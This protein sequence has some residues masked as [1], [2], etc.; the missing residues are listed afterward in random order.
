[1][2]I[3]WFDKNRLGVVR[4]ERVH[5]VTDVLSALQITYPY[6]PGDPLI[7]NLEVLRPKLEAAADKADGRPI[8]EVSFHSPVANP[9]KVIGTP[10]NYMKHVEE[11]EADPEINT[12]RFQGKVEQQGLFL[13]ANSAL[14]GPGDGIALR[15]PERRTDHELE[16]GVVIGKT[17]AEV[18]EA[19][20]LDYVAGYAIALDM[21]IRGP[22]DRSLRKSCDSY[23]ILGPW[24]VTADEIADP[25]N[26]D[27][28]LTIGGEPR[29][30]SNTRHM[31][32]D[33]RRQISWASQFYTLHPGDII[34]TGT[35]EGVGPIAPGDVL[36]CRFE[37][38]GTMDVAVRAAG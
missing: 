26:L 38:I 33:T 34:M 11:A 36:N 31:I 8:A 35:C 7:A 29:Q 5:D 21:S 12:E 19:E 30:D 13:K 37:A 17:A 10:A 6:P 1:M 3:A 4:G 24:L 9:S 14:V 32:L 23:A 27:F 20:A 2:K 25:D 28:T 16:L 18:S 22:E 15:F